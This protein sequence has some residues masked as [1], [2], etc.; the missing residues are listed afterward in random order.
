MF[1]ARSLHALPAALAFHGVCACTCRSHR[2]V[3]R[4]AVA[5]ASNL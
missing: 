1:D 3:V 2:A 5:G 4:E